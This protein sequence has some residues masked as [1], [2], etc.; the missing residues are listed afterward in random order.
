MGHMGSPTVSIVV[1]LYNKAAFIARALSSVL[2]QRFPPLEIVVVDDGSTDDGP[3]TVSRF[4]D[5]RIRLL[6]Q[7][8]Q[9][10]GVARNTGL[11]LARGKYVAFLDADD[12][13]LPSF[14]EAGISLLEEYSPKV[15][16]VY[17]GFYSCPGMRPNS[18]GVEEKISGA[19]AISPETDLRLVHQLC[20]HWVCA[21][22]MRTDVVRKWGGFF[23]KYKCFFHEDVFLSI[24]LAFNET[25]GV[26]PEPHVIYHT[27][28]SNLYGGGSIVNIQPSPVFEDVEDLL[29]AC[30]PQ[31]LPLLKRFL[32]QKAIGTG[33]RLAKLGYGK[34]A[35][36][37]IQRFHQEG[38]LSANEARKGRV[39]A[40]FAPLLPSIRWIWRKMKPKTGLHPYDHQPR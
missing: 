2:A 38:F 9:G 37:L 12:E 16:M 21:T 7:A 27:D 11:S 39:I 17:T 34:D 3:E 1:P 24:K 36:R 8:N 19:L 29:D 4:K 33:L 40:N 35:K 26:I 23:S 14:L 25:I 30:P 28:A 32:A 22:I 5:P 18:I 6:R 10:P 31:T 15:T 13:Y 20:H